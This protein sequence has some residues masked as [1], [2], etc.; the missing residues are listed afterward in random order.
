[1]LI[2]GWGIG[3]LSRQPYVYVIIGYVQDVEYLL[4]LFSSSLRR[5]INK[6]KADISEILFNLP[7][8]ISICIPTQY[9]KFEAGVGMTHPRVWRRHL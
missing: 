6:L 7:F 5:L 4:N 9:C 2:I 8:D 1:M 3:A